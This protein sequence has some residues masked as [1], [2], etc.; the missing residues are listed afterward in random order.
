MKSLL[1]GKSWPTANVLLLL[2]WV[3]AIF[4]IIHGWQI[5]DATAMHD[6]TQWGMF[7][8]YPFLPY[9]GKGAELLAGVLLLI[10]FLTRVAALLSVG[11]FLFITFFVGNG[12]FWMQDQ[13]PF[14]LAMF[15]LLFL[16][17][18]P[19]KYCVDKTA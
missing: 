10:G 18:G 9:V 2:R 14:L 19:V 13:H 7:K 1:S 6:F 8:A 16:F 17:T 15:G 12:Q 5:F 11:T 4:L 3:Y